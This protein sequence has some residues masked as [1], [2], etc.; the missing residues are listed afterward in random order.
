M[1]SV[2][3]DESDA[4]GLEGRGDRTVTYQASSPDEVRL[5]L[6]YVLFILAAKSC[7]TNIKCVQ[8]V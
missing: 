4:D 2:T 8:L 7:Y 6:F 1:D 5:I 3:S